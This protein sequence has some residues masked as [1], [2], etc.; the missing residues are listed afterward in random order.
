MKAHLTEIGQFE[1]LYPRQGAKGSLRVA[2]AVSKRTS[3]QPS[4]TDSLWLD[5]LFQG[6]SGKYTPE[7]ANCRETN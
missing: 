6:H 3:V 1:L 7:S 2:T 5:E 4:L